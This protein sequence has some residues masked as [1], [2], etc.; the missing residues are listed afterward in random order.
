MTLLG[1]RVLVEIGYAT[2][3][4]GIF[5]FD[6]IAGTRMYCHCAVCCF[7]IRNCTCFCNWE[8]VYNQSLAVIELVFV[9]GVVS[10]ISHW[11]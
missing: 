8:C 9:V 4:I 1:Y 11:L 3:S 5:S 2:V 7:C 10:V 6:R